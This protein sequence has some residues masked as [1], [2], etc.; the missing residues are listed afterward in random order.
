MAE[1]MQEIDLCSPLDTM[2]ALKSN[3]VPRRTSRW[4]TLTRRDGK[5]NQENIAE[6]H[7]SF[8]SFNS[9]YLDCGFFERR[10]FTWMYFSLMKVTF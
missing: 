1:K 4:H 8:I 10:L 7:L 3:Q 2:E 9:A 6:M 5:E